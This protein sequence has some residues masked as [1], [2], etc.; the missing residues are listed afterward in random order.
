MKNFLLFILVF[1]IQHAYSQPG[2]LDSTFNV[3]YYSGANNHIICAELQPD[4]KILIGGIF[5]E[6][7]DTLANRLARLNNDGTLDTTFNI[8]V[9]INGSDPAITGLGIQPDGKIIITGVFE[10]VNGILVNNIARLNSDGSAD[11]AFITNLGYGAWGNIRSCAIQQDGKI[12]IVGGFSYFNWIPMGFITRLN[13]DGTIDQSFNVGNGADTYIS[14]VLLQPDGK[15]II[16]GGLSN[17]NGTPVPYIARLETD[18]TLDPTFSTNNAPNSHVQTVSLQSDGKIVIGGDFWEVDGISQ[19][20][21]SR[22]NND[23]TLDQ[24]FNLGT[25]PNSNVKI[26]KVQ[27]DDKIFIVG[28][29]FNSYNGFPAERFMR[30][31]ADGSVDTT[32]DLSSS[33]N[34][35]ITAILIQP[36]GKVILVGKFTS[37]QNKSVSSGHITRMNGGILFEMNI[38]SCGPYELNSE[39]Y[40]TSGNFTQNYTSSSGMDSTILLN[41]TIN[42]IDVSI[43]NSNNFFTANENG[44]SSY[45]WINCSD[46]NP[47]FNETAQTFSPL[48]NGDYAVIVTNDNCSDTSDCFNVNSVAYSEI[49]ALGAHSVYPNPGKDIFTVLCEFE[50]DRIEIYNSSG[51]FLFDQ[52]ND[53]KIDLTNVENGLYFIQI[54]SKNNL[55][56]NERIIRN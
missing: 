56:F 52:Q 10:S 36:D 4:G 38:I 8:G 9:G 54:Y 34:D 37:V 53:N 27:P 2:T 47:L 28:D 1:Y 45:Q 32:F 41:L 7:N 3:G 25:G 22:L 30:L 12:I 48:V 6:Y 46:L 40:A 13:S 11:T 20:F 35:T 55:K 42:E 15:I 19:N 18:G 16:S 43:T 29:Y 23:G 50:I 49:S 31:N 5:T 33:V 44:A 24:T 14:T 51:V 26:S 39:L 21:L 17:F